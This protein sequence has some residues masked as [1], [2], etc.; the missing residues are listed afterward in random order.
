L[1]VGDD[2]EN[3]RRHHGDEK[4]LARLGAVAPTSTIFKDTH[5]SLPGE[6]KYLKFRAL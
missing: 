4:L 6:K 3:Q 1:G 2:E 5:Y